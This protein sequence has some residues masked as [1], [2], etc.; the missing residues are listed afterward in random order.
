MSSHGYS[1]FFV[2][3]SGC[4]AGLTTRTY[5]ADI[6]GRRAGDGE[7]ERHER[8]L[9]LRLQ[10]E[11]RERHLDV[12]RR[13]LAGHHAVDQLD[14]LLD[15]DLLLL[16]ALLGIRLRLLG[17]CCARSW[18]PRRPTQPQGHDVFPSSKSPVEHEIR[19]R[20]NNRS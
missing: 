4:A 16:A 20:W 11:R 13:R 19:S 5:I 18:P 7:R 14:Q 17:E 6:R 12:G 1:I 10:E 2:F 8:P 3:G 15:L 9:L